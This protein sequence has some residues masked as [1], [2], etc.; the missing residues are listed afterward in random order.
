MWF[1]YWDWFCSWGFVLASCFNGLYLSVN[2]LQITDFLTWRTN[3]ERSFW[4]CVIQNKFKDKCPSNSLRRGKSGTALLCCGMSVKANKQTG[5][6][7]KIGFNAA[8]ASENR[9]SSGRKSH[10]EKVMI[11]SRVSVREVRLLY[12]GQS[13]ILQAIYICILKINWIV[14]LN[15]YVKQTSPYVGIVEIWWETALGTGT[16]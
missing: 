12:R 15:P 4:M 5:T 6:P 13:Q 16:L 8:R 3:L 7:R 10:G 11:S 9:C 2:K 14:I 1:W